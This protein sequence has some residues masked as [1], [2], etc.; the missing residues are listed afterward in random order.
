MNLKPSLYFLVFFTLV[1]CS[2]QES[3][4]KEEQLQ[5]LEVLIESFEV[6]A[7]VLM[8]EIS[9][10]ADFHERI[11]QKKEQILQAHQSDRYHFA[12]YYSSNTPDSDSLKSSIVITENV[13]DYE[14]ARQEVRMTNALDSAFASTFYKYQI[15]AQVY[16]NSAQQVSRVFPAYDAPNILDSGIDLTDFNFYYEGD[17]AHNPEKGPVWI[18]DPYVDPAGKGWI[19]SLVHPVYEQDD[20]FSVIGIDIQIEQFIEEFLDNQPGDYLVVS[21]KGDIV[22][23]TSAAIEALSLPPLKNHVYRETIRSDNFRISD[24]NLFNSKSREVRAMA[25]A[26]LLESKEEFMFEEE[27]FLLDAISTKFTLIDWYAIK[28]NFDT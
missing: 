6:Q 25:K 15:V 26:F 13:I 8:G 1:S 11:L 19:L 28:I 3:T 2:S 22:G 23:G 4:S 16:V 10:L 27:D 12:G 17:L 9:N 21:G 7:R 24:F 5:Q 20:L 14:R 18:P